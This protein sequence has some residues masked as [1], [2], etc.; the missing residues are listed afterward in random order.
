M[1]VVLWDWGG[2]GGLKGYSRICSDVGVNLSNLRVYLRCSVVKVVWEFLAM[3]YLKFLELS[4]LV[5][6]VYQNEL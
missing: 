2:G 5:I 3:Y 6:G 1:V 4:V